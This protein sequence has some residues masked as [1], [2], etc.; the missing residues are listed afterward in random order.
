V[1]A[2]LA[3]G[4]I[5]YPS[6][7]MLLLLEQYWAAPTRTGLELLPQARPLS[8]TLAEAIDWY[9]AIGYLEPSA[10]SEAAQRT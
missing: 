1:L 3:P 2:P 5:A 6:V 9:R 7:G 8:R 4:A 10:P